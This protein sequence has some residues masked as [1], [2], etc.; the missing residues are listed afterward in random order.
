MPQLQPLLLTDRAA[1][2]VQHSFLPRDI[3]NG[4]ATVEESTGVPIANNRFSISSRKT[5]DGRYKIT[6]KGVFPVVQTQSING[7][8]TP[9]VVRTSY[10]D[11]TF[12]FEG[13]STFDERNNVVGMMRSAL[14]PTNPLVNET[15]VTLQSVY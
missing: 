11:M 2:P 3:V 13:T 12:S 1:T 7:I 6:L 14:D 10:V 8:S 5:R 9:A 4:V 15:L